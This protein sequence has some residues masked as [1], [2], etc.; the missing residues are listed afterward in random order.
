MDGDARRGSLHRSLRASRKPGLTDFLAGQASLELVT[1]KTGWASLD[2]IGA[3]SRFRDSPELLASPAMVG[4][5]ARLR[6]QYQVILVDS[7]PLGSGVDPFTLG[8]LTG[9]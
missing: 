2:F 4:L 9:S 5:M 6:N 8:A 7:P 1:Q 3:G